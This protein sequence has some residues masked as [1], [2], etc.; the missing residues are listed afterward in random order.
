MKRRVKAIDQFLN[1]DSLVD[2]VSNNVGIL[3]ILAAFMALLALINPGFALKDPVRLDQSRSV[4]RLRVPW[5]HPTHKTPIFFFVRDNRVQH[6]D[7]RE[8][9]AALSQRTPGSRVREES[10]SFKSLDLRFFPVTN[11]IYCLE[12]KPHP[13]GGEPWPVAAKPGSEW[14]QTL[15]RYPPERHTFFF[16][17]GGDSFALFRDIRESLWNRQVE[18]GWKPALANTPLE[19]CNGFENATGF[20]PQ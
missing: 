18:V 16:W 20:Q 11:Q 4:P 13:G 3:I 1:L 2:I 9:Y 6:L 12:I 7:M 19:V 17:V 8:F 5:S 14:E 10:F 15:R